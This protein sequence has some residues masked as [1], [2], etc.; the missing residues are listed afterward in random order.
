MNNNTNNKTQIE[1]PQETTTLKP[2]PKA[3]RRADAST[4]TYAEPFNRDRHGNPI[5]R[6]QV[7]FRPVVTLDGQA[8]VDAA[9]A[10]AESDE[11]AL[12]GLVRAKAVNAVKAA[13]NAREVEES[14]HRHMEYKNAL[15]EER[16]QA[17]E[18]ELAKAE[19]VE[20]DARAKSAEACAH[21]RIEFRPDSP[22]IQF[23][24]NEP[25]SVE[26]LAGSEGVASPKA[27]PS[28]LSRL[29]WKFVAT[30]GA[31][32][33]F[34][35]GLGALIGGVEVSALS[36]EMGKSGFWI[37]IGIVVMAIVGIPMGKQAEYVGASMTRR[38]FRFPWLGWANVANGLL[39]LAGIAFA[40]I[41]IE[42]KVEQLGLFKSIRAE[43]SLEGVILSQADLFWV[44]LMLVVPIV[45]AY[46]ISGLGDGERAASR[47]YLLS[48]RRGKRDELIRTEEYAT[49]MR[50]HEY[51]C[52]AMRERARV[53]ADIARFKAMI[54]YDRTQD[55]DYRIED[56]QNAAAAASHDA[57]DF[58]LFVSGV[59][60]YRP[61]RKGLRSWLRSL[62]WGD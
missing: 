55:E 3:G 9:E 34:G 30:F 52:S 18:V 51:L 5:P 48:V 4:Y 16:I 53:E 21:A 13:E 19:Q 45:A 39:L 42:S 8:L 50:L 28:L 59:T 57:E 43:S 49:A 44:S 33:V 25:A 38:G 40:I 27:E 36:D 2:S 12:A 37:A 17:L 61:R 24:E 14:I 58:L 41:K 1:L 10:A 7:Y 47:D 56:V 35:I 20:T 11:K 29:W 6:R 46:V 60:R 54:R 32:A 26:E 22:T 31:G 23:A 15:A 62:F